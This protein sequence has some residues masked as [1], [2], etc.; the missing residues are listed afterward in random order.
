MQDLKIDIIQSNLF[1]EDRDANIEHLDKLI[2][3][4]YQGADLI[5]LPEMFNTAFSMNPEEYAE[6]YD[7][8]TISWLKSKAA[9]LQAVVCGSMMFVEDGKY[10]NRVIWMR[11][12][13][14]FDYYNKRHLFRMGLEQ[15][16][17]S[18]GTENLIVE[19]KGW[20]VKLLVCYD[21]RFPV[22]SKNKFDGENYDYDVL[23]Y[24]ANW[25]AGRHRIWKTLLSARAIENQAYIAGVNRVGTDGNEI[26]YSGDS[27]MLNYTGKTMNELD[28]GEE[29]VIHASLNFDDLAQFRKDFTVALD[30]D[31]F[32]IEI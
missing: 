21:L 4:N 7:G 17:Y 5:L 20:K 30:W 32:N 10:Y 19:V 14:T 12:D 25:P 22:W 9:E 18:E 31:K 6:T 1:W 16:H 8:K 11:P 24:L 28:E 13:G 26:T 2:S 23:V 27:R 29:G 15:E 3:S